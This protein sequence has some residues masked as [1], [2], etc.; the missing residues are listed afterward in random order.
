MSN[1]SARTVL[2]DRTALIPGI[3]W[4]SMRFVTLLHCATKPLLILPRIPHAKIVT[5]QVG[6]GSSTATFT[7]HAD[8]LTNCSSFFRSSFNGQFAEAKSSTMTYPETTPSAFGLFLDW[9]YRHQLTLR[10]TSISLIDYVDLWLLADKLNI[11]G[12][13]ASAIAAI[14]RHATRERL[15]EL[16]FKKIWDQTMDGYQVRE[17]LLENIVRHIPELPLTKRY[18]DGMLIELFK[19]L[20]KFRAR[21]R[22]VLEDGNGYKVSNGHLIRT[23]HVAGSEQESSVTEVDLICDASGFLK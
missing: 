23:R 3:E 8:F 18:P 7:V 1:P 10:N 16:D 5:I 21:A 15:Q 9:A 17:T 4:P 13:Q 20:Q 22:E 19:V 6:Q 12:L 2:A 11:P 14:E